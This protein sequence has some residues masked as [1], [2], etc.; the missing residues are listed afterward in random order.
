MT[1]RPPF[2][3]P[4][5]RRVDSLRHLRVPGR[6][7]Q[8]GVEATAAYQASRTRLVSPLMRRI[9]LVNI[10]PLALLGVTVLFLGQF[11]N[12]L[13]ASEVSGLREQAR[14][15][16]GA[17]GQSAVRAIHPRPGSGAQD[18]NYALETA[19]ARPLLQRLTEP[20][21]AA[22]ARLFGPDGRLVADNLIDI[23][24]SPDIPL[25]FSPSPHRAR[26]IHMPAP[27]AY[28]R[29]LSWLWASHNPRIVTLDTDEEDTPDHPPGPPE[30][31]GDPTT[32]AANRPP[33]ETPPY[34][35]RTAQGRLLITV[36]EPVIHDGRTVG[37]VQLTRMAWQVDRSLFTIRST[38]LSLFLMALVLTVLLSWYLSLTI[39]RPLLRLAASAQ[40]MRDTT[41]RSGTV[42]AR[43]LARRDE[44]G[45]LAR[46]LQASAQ[47]LWKRMDAIERF[48]ADVSHE[49]KNPLSSIR[50][51]IETLLRIEDLNQQRRLLTIINADVRRL[52]RLITDISDASRLDAEMS[53][54]KAEPVEIAPLL[55]VL[56]EIH[57]ATRQEGQPIIVTNI[58]QESPDHPLCVLAVEDRLVQVLRN[59]IGNAISFSPPNGRIVL[60]A[61][62]TGKMVSISVADEG[63]GIPQAKLDSIFDR[64]YSER[65]KD[66]NFGQH[67]G[68]GLSI[69]RQIIE[70]LHGT[71]SVENL[72]DRHGAITGACFTILLP[73][74]M[75]LPRQ[76]KG[77]APRRD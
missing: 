74:A 8:K 53:R 28:E 37:V 40:V 10:L 70:A 49:I 69:S 71:I 44:I 34:I 42:P 50:S 52:D 61:A 41:G 58:T 6:R 73:R 33:P 68:L 66:E 2:L 30:D 26:A 14:I 5:S 1:D 12:S 43:L 45:D 24:D 72:L 9:L 27:S 35:R 36:A 60:S 15:Y 56:A 31:N 18:R 62:E 17:L 46:A 63:P 3:A 48:A 11:R 19:L 38:I 54:A 16:A 64:F 29:F 21:P 67:S 39:A 57:Q 77:S 55:G 75:P 23:S 65:P 32:P 51:A 4:L 13:L 7:P 20:S 25:T 47:A 76:G 59:L 22:H